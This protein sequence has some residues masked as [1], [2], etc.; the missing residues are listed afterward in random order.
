MKITFKCVGLVSIVNMFIKS[1]W[2]FLDAK[3]QRTHVVAMYT[4]YRL[5]LTS[6]VTTDYYLVTTECA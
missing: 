2:N 6:L 4:W 5:L 1:F 3:V